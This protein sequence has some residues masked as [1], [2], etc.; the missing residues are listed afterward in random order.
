[1]TEKGHMTKEEILDHVGDWIDQAQSHP[2]GYP[3]TTRGSI[4]VRITGYPGNRPHISVEEKVEV[5]HGTLEKL[6]E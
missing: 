5:G 2:E 1:M 3:Y 4:E 6:T